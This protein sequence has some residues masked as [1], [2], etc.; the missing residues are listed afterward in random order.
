MPPSLVFLPK[1]FF[2]Q[3]SSIGAN[4]KIEIV[5]KRLFRWPPAGNI[6]GTLCHKLSHTV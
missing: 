1:H 4:I 3:L 5:S 6:V 2:L